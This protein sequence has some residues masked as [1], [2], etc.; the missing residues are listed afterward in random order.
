MVYHGR[1]KS[2]DKIHKIYVASKNLEALLERYLHYY[3]N[4]MFT[5]WTLVSSIG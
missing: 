5:V 2:Y 1:F 4:K 3:A